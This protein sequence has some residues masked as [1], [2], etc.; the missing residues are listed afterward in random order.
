MRLALGSLCAL[1]ALTLSS[2]GRSQVVDVDV[3]TQVFHEP[4]ALSR[5]TVLTPQATLSAQPLDWLQVFAGYEA[6]IVSGASEVV[7]AGPLLEDQPDIV[8]RA[9]VEDF[10]QVRSEEHTSELQSQ[11]NL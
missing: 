4:S 1:G 11:S 2:A 9:S 10:R 8:S 6:D 7:K 3:R 5:M